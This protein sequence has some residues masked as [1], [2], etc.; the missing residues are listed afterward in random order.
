MASYGTREFFSQWITAAFGLFVFYYY[1]TVIGLETGLATL[2]FIIYQIWNAINDPLTGYVMERVQFPWEK[3]RGYRRTP[4]I[5]LGGIMW[6]VTYLAIFLGP[7]ENLGTNQGAIFGWYVATLC[8]YDLFGTLFD[9]NAVSIFPEKFREPN[10]RRT[11]QA[12]GTLLGIVG[13]VAANLL[14]PQFLVKGV[15]STYRNS[16]MFTAVAGILPFLLLIPGVFETRKLREHYKHRR[17]NIEK[18]QRTE[19]FFKT[20]KIVFSNRRFVGKIILFFGYQVGVV[21]LQMSAL[22]IVTFLLDTDPSNTS[23]LMGAMLVGALLTVPV[24]MTLSKRVN[25][26]RLLCLIGG[27]LLLLSFI[28]MIFVQGMI[29]WMISLFFFGIALG[30]QWFMDPPTMGDVIDDAAVRTGRRDTSVYYSYQSLSFKLGQVLG[31]AVIGIVHMTTGFKAG[32]E[33][34]SELAAQT[35]TLQMALFGIRIHSAIVPAAVV[36]ITTLLF[37][38]LYDL[39]PEKV[40]ENKRKLDEMG[41]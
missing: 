24:W 37:W 13:L 7:T 35:P 33:T 3:K 2:A 15:A 36:L 19:G 29:G 21:M 38:K 8:L 23:Y 16:A 4:F 39:T 17:E 6:L 28:P 12:F 18:G 14:A 22:Y 9:V 40:A 20:L 11:V 26:N 10:E 34:L 25:N 1:E 41:I 32:A 5:F 30:N 27:F 31:A